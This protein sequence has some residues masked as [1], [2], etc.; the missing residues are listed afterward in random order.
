M[1]WNRRSDY[2]LGVISLI[3]F[4]VL[5]SAAIGWTRWLAVFWLVYPAAVAWGLY[6]GWQHAR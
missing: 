2:K 1:D 6:Q 3:V 4:V 5:A